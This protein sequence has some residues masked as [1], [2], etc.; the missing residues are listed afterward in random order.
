MSGRRPKRS[1]GAGAMAN[2]DEYW[3]FKRRMRFSDEPTARGDEIAAYV[4]RWYEENREG[5]WDRH[6]ANGDLR[7]GHADEF[8]LRFVAFVASVFEA[9]RQQ[10]AG[11]NRT[12]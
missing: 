9:A 4:R 7:G 6:R 5:W 10:D 12:F 1:D 2:D 3:A 8:M 11:I